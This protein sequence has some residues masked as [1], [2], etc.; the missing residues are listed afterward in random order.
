MRI[1]TKILYFMI[2][3][4]ILISCNQHKSTKPL[5][6]YITWAAHDQLSDTVKLSESLANHQMDA[7]LKLRENGVKMDYF[8]L[9]M[10]WFH[11]DS[12]YRSFNSEWKNGHQAFFRRAKE[13]N[14]QLGMWLSANVLGWNEDIRWLSY[15]DTLSS[16]ICK[17]NRWMVLY[18]GSWPGYFNSILE[19]WYKEGVTLFKIDFA[20]FWA[21]KE[22]DETK[23]P[24]DRI[25]KMNEDAFFNIISSFR[26][27]HPDSK[28][29]AYNGFI[30]KENP[31]KAT[32]E[33][34]LKV[35]DAI[36]C[37]D[38]QPSV[39][40]AFN[41]W[42]S[43]SLYSDQMHYGFVNCGIPYN[44]IDNSQF[45]LSNTGTGYYRGKTQWKTMLLSTLAKNSSI[46]TYYGNIDLLTGSDI[47]WMAKAQQLFYEMDTMHCIQEPN[48][49]TP[50]GYHLVNSRGGLLFL[51][52]PGQEIM[53]VRLPEEIKNKKIGL[54]FSQRGYSGN[55]TDS[56]ITIAPEQSILLG[57]GK[58]TGDKYSQG[59]EENYIVPAESIPVEIQNR[60]DSAGGTMF[61]VP[62]PKKGNLRLVF[63]FTDN[64]GKPVHIYGGASPKG[65]FMAQVLEIKAFSEGKE[66]PVK[67]NYNLQIWSGLAWA[68][69]ELEED[70]L[71]ELTGDIRIEF[72]VRDTNFKGNI[73][74]NCY[75]IS[76][77]Q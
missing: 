71:K 70:I 21:A 49:K 7:F 1:T 10:H 54:L 58:Y 33:K 25:T 3:V 47:T 32:G 65:K 62:N 12:L 22:G 68:T 19:Y 73:I 14:V 24:A 17:D 15:Q 57:Y 31:D 75:H 5:N 43:V 53:P 55:F 6:I 44:R 76:Y 28:F 38:P 26:E 66:L 34:W 36:F 37:G 69:G 35:F 39:V 4:A 2:A 48:G 11:K 63:Q 8:L 16:S 77:T 50:F 27:R 30:N 9:D 41:F 13:N 42:H 56:V 74:P 46:Q 51:V 59:E 18:E 60:K 40:P 64:D 23:Y 72:Y 61:M 52:N 45:M 67:T 20:A 29:I